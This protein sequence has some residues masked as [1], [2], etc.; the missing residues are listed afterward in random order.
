MEI[1]NMNL[2]IIES[3]LRRLFTPFGEVAS[4]EVF[5]DKINYRSHGRAQVFMPIDKQARNAMVGLQG[6]LWAGKL[7]RITEVSDD[8]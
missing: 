4:V 2:N 5:R 3:D 8:Q 1:T 6:L 7:I